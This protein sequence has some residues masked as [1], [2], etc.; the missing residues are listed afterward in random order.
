M[1]F[2]FIHRFPIRAEIEFTPSEHNLVKRALFNT[3]ITA[4]TTGDQLRIN[5]DAHILTRTVLGPEY[6]RTT[7]YV[8]FAGHLQAIIQSIN[9]LEPADTDQLKVS[10]FVEQLSDATQMLTGATRSPAMIEQIVAET[11]IPDNLS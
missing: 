3:L 6:S 8:V 9:D 1:D 7:R 5:G 2:T 10:S 11:V 4:A